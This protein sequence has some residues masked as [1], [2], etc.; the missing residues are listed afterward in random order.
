MKK[1][2]TTL[3]ATLALTACNSGAGSNNNTQSTNQS[4]TETIRQSLSQTVPGWTSYQ[5][6][7]AMGSIE[8]F[9]TPSASQDQDPCQLYGQLTDQTTKKN[10]LFSMFTYVNGD[11]TS[12]IDEGKITALM[13]EAKLRNEVQQQAFM[14][15]FVIYTTNYS[16]GE[17]LVVNDYTTNLVTCIRNFLQALV[18]IEANQYQAQNNTNTIAT[19]LLNPDMINQML[20]DISSST[21]QLL[22]YYNGTNQI[23]IQQA[24]Q[25]PTITNLLNQLKI[26]SNQIPSQ[27]TN[28]FS[29]YNYFINWIMHQL[30]NISYAWVANSSGGTPYTNGYIHNIR[31]GSPVTSW[32]P[33]PSEVIQQDTNILNKYNIINLSDSNLTP[34]FIAFDKYG[35]DEFSADNQG[36]NYKTY[37]HFYNAADWQASLGLMKGI[38]QGL[39]IMLWQIPGGHIENDGTENTYGNGGDYDFQYFFGDG[40]LN[41][42]TNYGGQDT[43][44]SIS[45]YAI[46]TN[47]SIID[48]L[49]MPVGSQSAPAYNLAQDNNSSLVGDG[50][51]AI[52]W[53]AEQ[54]ASGIFPVNGGE[55][56]QDN[57]WLIDHINKY[58]QSH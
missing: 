7:I 6:K 21:G 23:Q 16:Q 19:V 2:V 50:V 27:V 57:Q 56:S 18:D 53:G 32:M 30:P 54:Y 45:Q 25:D 41:D 17:E 51:F 39:P 33:Q 14:P 37:F 8:G 35:T 36:I 34:N 15:T 20:I 46:S 43:I 31:Y 58:Y 52:M 11:T 28:N 55:L 24:L 26:N 22:N 48:Y 49:K 44:N 38:A 42:L 4:N 10:N 29:G 13:Q 3:L 5:G 1:L 9:C 47:T 12:G 40:M